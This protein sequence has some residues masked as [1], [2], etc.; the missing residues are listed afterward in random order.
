MAFPT[1]TANF[2]GILWHNTLQVN[3]GRR[4][5][6]SAELRIGLIDR[7][8]QLRNSKVLAYFSYKPLD[9]NILIPLYK[10]LKEIG[11]MEN[12]GI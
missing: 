3:A 1:H 8:E 11:H 2:Y 9:D 10:Q 7:L 5:G 4:L 12:F 6:L